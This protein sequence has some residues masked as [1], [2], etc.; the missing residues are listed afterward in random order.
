MRTAS[1]RTSSRTPVRFTYLLR[2]LLHFIIGDTGRGQRDLVARKFLR[3]MTA[4]TLLVGMTRLHRLT[5]DNSRCA[6]HAVAS[7]S[8]C[9]QTVR[10]DSGIADR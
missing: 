6:G 9:E 4:T 1:D 3:G 5:T 10:V 7:T 2:E 8:L